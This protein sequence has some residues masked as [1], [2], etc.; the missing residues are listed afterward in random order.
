MYHVSKFQ[1]DLSGKDQIWH[2]PNLDDLPPD[3]VPIQIL[4]SVVT[5]WS[6]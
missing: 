4:Y 1:L 5:V 3:E 6:G 2:N